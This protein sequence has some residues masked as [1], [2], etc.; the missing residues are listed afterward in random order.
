MSLLKWMAGIAVALLAAAACSLA[1]ARF[2]DGPLG[3]V[4][5]GVFKSGQPHT[6]PEPDWSSVR[7]IPT[8]EFQLL[9]PA[10]S[11]TTWSVEHEGKIYIPSGY[12]NSSLGRAWKQWPIEAERDGRAILRVQGRLYERQLLRVRTGSVLEP[13][14]EKLAAKYGVTATADAVRSGSLWIFELAARG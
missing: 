4:P 7:E 6:G 8:V 2:A 1:L 3:L 12:M 13:L 11:R 5:G 10:R 14:L 9:Q